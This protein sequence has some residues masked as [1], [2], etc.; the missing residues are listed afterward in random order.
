MV[1][2]YTDPAELK[3][4]L[5]I[6]TKDDIED[7]L[8][9]IDQRLRVESDGNKIMRLLDNRDILEKALENY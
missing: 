5:P 3:Q 2:P 1:S 4:F 9:T 7:L 6:M 8:K